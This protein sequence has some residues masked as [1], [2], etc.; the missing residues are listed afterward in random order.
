MKHSFS[1]HQIVI[2]GLRRIKHLNESLIHIHKL[3]EYFE[4]KKDIAKTGYDRDISDIICN[5]FSTIY[6]LSLMKNNSITENV[7]NF[8]F[9]N[10]LRFNLPRELLKNV[11]EFFVKITKRN[12]QEIHTRLSQIPKILSIIKHS[13]VL[14]LIKHNKRLHESYNERESYAPDEYKYKIAKKEYKL[15]HELPTRLIKEAQPIYKCIKFK[16]RQYI[17]KEAD[18][19]NLIQKQIEKLIRVKQSQIGI[20]SFILFYIIRWYQMFKSDP[21]KLYADFN[22][23]SLNQ[24]SM[25]Q[26]KQ[27][28][29]N[30]EGIESLRDRID[31][32]E[33][34][35]PYKILQA[36]KPNRII[37]RKKSKC[38]FGKGIKITPYFIECVEEYRKRCVKCEVNTANISDLLDTMYTKYETNITTHLSNT[39]RE[40][41][42][43][44]LKF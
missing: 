17:N 5:L 31:N 42:I 20:S 9:N 36:L 37:K 39:T 14:S 33:S 8:L 10:L 12:N 41:L 19:N 13:D 3:F 44:H 18:H 34:V 43:K 16:L 2:F 22:M 23:F 29:L 1:A 27:I 28:I 7:D 4:N 38:E 25:R 40:Y 15:L 6:A 21:K 32:V 11:T 35:N 24:E 30:N 26:I